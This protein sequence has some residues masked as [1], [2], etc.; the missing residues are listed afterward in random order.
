MNNK[1][2]IIFGGAGYIGRN[3]LSVFLDNNVFSKY[4]ICDI[5]PLI[6]FETRKM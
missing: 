2:V 4:I 5:K 1:V 3:T 6:G